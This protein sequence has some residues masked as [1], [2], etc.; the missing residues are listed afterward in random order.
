MEDF[1]RK[2]LKKFIKFILDFAID[3]NLE[4]N[5]NV[6]Y[7]EFETDDLDII[8]LDIENKFTKTIKQ[9]IEFYLDNIENVIN[10]F[11]KQSCEKFIIELKNKVRLACKIGLIEYLK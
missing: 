9:I 10:C 2:L 4:T 8:N 6:L 7:N 11:S 3:D 1:D 5:I